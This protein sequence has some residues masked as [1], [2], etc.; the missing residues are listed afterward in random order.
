MSEYGIYANEYLKIEVKDKEGMACTLKVNPV[1]QFEGSGCIA[2]IY[3][4]GDK[5]LS[6]QSVD[7]L[8]DYILSRIEFGNLEGVFEDEPDDYFMGSVLRKSGEIEIND[9]N[10]WYLS[11]FRRLQEDYDRFHQ[12]LKERFGSFEEIGEIV[13]HQYHDA[14]GEM[15]DFVDYTCCPEG[16]DEEELREFFEDNLSV[17]SEIENI[18]NCFE[19]GYFNGN[20]FSADETLTID[21][22][23]GRAHKIMT[24][25]NVC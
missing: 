12:Q 14:G 25:T 17:Y 16:A 1:G 24:I 3:A 7:E 9:D 22:T 15:C 2:T 11:Y 20:Q 5:I 18:M 19:D 4:K 10:S 13:I 23:N 6:M 8:C 21:V